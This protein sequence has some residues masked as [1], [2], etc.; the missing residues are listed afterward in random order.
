MG[1][2]FQRLAIVNRGEPAMRAIHAVR[3]LNAARE[4]DPE[5]PAPLTTIALYTEPERRSMFVREADEAVLLGPATFVDPRDGERKNAYLDY[6]RLRQV[7]V[8]NRVEAVWVGWGFVAEH[9]A[10]VDL[11]D[12]LGIVFVGPSAEVMRRLGDK[13]SSKQLAEQARVPVAPWSGGPV[14]TLEQ[15]RR[16]AE[17]LG[18]PLMIKATAGG[19]GRGIRKVRSD[20]ELRSAFERASSEAL[21]AF[22]DGT[23]FL[24]R[25]LA[26]ARHV[27]VQIIADRHGTA[28]GLGVR[29]CTIQ[30]RN[31]K[32]LEESPSPALTAEQDAEL[33]AAAVRLAQTVG[34]HNAG[35]VEF[36]YDESSQTFSFMEVN[37]R[38]QV[39]HPVTE[40]TTGVDLVKLQ[41]HVARG[42]RLEGEAPPA[43]GAAI[44]V[45]LNAEDPENAFAPAPGRIDLMRL[46][47]G[48]GLRIDTGVEAG[49]R[50]PAEFDSMI[51][52]IIAWG[53]NR[54]EALARLRRA[55][56]DAA[57]VVHGGTTNKGFL[58]DLL[59][60]DEVK[61]G[62]VD[63]GWLDR[64]VV[65]GGHLSH[66]H[67]EIA[68]IEA[69][70]CV[71]EAETQVEQARFM[72]SAAGGRPQ[73]SDA[74]AGTAE[75]EIYGQRYRPGIYRLGPRRFRLE[76]DGHWIDV[77]REKLGDFERWLTIAGQRYR[78]L[79]VDQEVAHLVEVEGVPHRVS[80]DEGGLV[81]A[82][83]PAVVVAVA[84]AE[85]D[86]VREG[87]RLAVLEAMKMETAV[88]ARFSGTVRE[89]LVT[90]G[91]QVATGAALLRLEPPAG[92]EAGAARAQTLRLELDHLQPAT[93][94]DPRPPECR[95]V[96]EELRCLILGYDVGSGHL[97]YLMEDRGTLCRRLPAD[98]PELL[99]TEEELLTL[100]VD[101][102][103]LFARQPD[104]D[105][106]EDAGRLSASAYLRAYLRDL[107]AGGEGL[108]QSFLDKLRQA[109]AHY[110]I[111]ELER[112]PALE[113]VL[114]RIYRSQRRVDEQVAPILS[115]LER[116]LEHLPLLAGS[117]GEPPRALLDRLIAETRGRF[118]AI[119]DCA[120]EVRYRFF[121]QTLWQE[122]RE[123]A[124]AESEA[125]LEALG[126]GTVEASE[127]APRMAALIECP[128]P[129]K[130]FISS[131]FDDAPE[132]LQRVMLEVLTRRYYRLRELENL[133]VFHRDG[134]TVCV[135]DYEHRWK[136]FH[137]LTT[138]AGYRD[139]GASLEALAPLVRECPAHDEVILDLYVWSEE[140][141]GERATIRSRVLELLEAIDF[142]RPVIQL[143][144]AI[145][146]PLGGL[147]M[148]GVEHLTFRGLDAR[149]SGNL[150]REELN[151]AGFVEE[152]VYGGLHPMMGRRLLIW[153]LA[154]F[155]I[156]RLQPT[157]EDVYVFRGVARNNPRDERIFAL[158]E[159]RDLTPVR[160]GG[161][162]VVELPHLERMYLAAL[163]GIRRFQSQRAPRERLHWNRVLLYVW[164]VVE[165][166]PDEIHDLANRLAPEALGLG[167]EKVVVRARLKP[168]GSG[169][170]STAD[171][172]APRDTELHIWHRAGQ[173]SVVRFRKPSDRP[174]QPLTRYDQKVVRLRQRGLHDPYEVIARLAPERGATGSDFPP[175][176]F[177][178]YDLDTHGQL[179]PV[180]RPPGGGKAN[181]VVG[182]IRNFT[183]KVPEGMAR[184]I[185]L[186]DPGQAMGSLAEP[187]CRRILSA[188]DLAARRRVP[189]EWFAVSAGAKIAMDSGTENMDWIARV[190]RRLV[191]LT[192]KGLEVNIIVP[193]I[194]V[195]AQPY[196]N[197]EATMLMHTRG[198]LIMTPE[199][200]M[201]LTGKQALDY[202]GGVSAEDNQGI[203][204]YE[205]IM[206]PNGQ[207]Q[208]FARDL[209]EA[210][211]ILLRYYE[212]SYVVPGERFPRR[213]ATTDEPSRDVS[214]SSHGRRDGTHFHRVGDIFS[215]ERN[216]GR[217]KA[218][219]VRR[220]MAAVIDR[221]LPPLE[222]WFGMRDAEIGVVWD[223]HL[224]GYPV[225]LLGLESRPLSRL[226]FVPAD[227][228]AQWT[229][230]TLFPQSSK[231][232]ARAINAASGNRPVVILANLSGFDGSPE[233]MRSWQLEY[234]AEIG[235]AVVNFDGP[236]V[237]CVIS[238]YH[239]GA[240]VVFSG[241]LNENLEVA[242][243]EG[244][245]ASVIGG[246]PAA[247]VVFAREVQRRTR[248]DS[249]VAEL[250]HAILGA[251]GADKVRLQSQLQEVFKAVHSEKLS[252]VAEEFDRVH[253]IHRARKVGSVDRIIPP[254]NLR[255]YLIDAV[256]RGMRRILDQGAADSPGP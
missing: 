46:P 10:F 4:L 179:V 93:V 11:C 170:I 62:A 109:L 153:R 254:A 198:I 142:G 31:Q 150:S 191:E 124:Y 231:K 83:S 39:E 158:A 52:K 107:D 242:A 248:E 70:I 211:K 45:R 16:H 253:S 194:N 246:A 17:R 86:D 230:G 81:R 30:R 121:D 221:D 223:A 159:V 29:D 7:M 79:S 136:R 160:D 116:R 60:R 244:S 8:E 78:V 141:A 189:L 67:A 145:S 228:P 6:N 217:K 115:V 55:L 111:R 209:G 112:T 127:R 94:D 187:E 92:A 129:L 165:L 168:S 20:A 251:G 147:G 128:Q 91:V 38:L 240:F 98:D 77:E 146:S 138:H 180:D 120:R 167:I 188:L 69:A 156:E 58:L 43:R 3:E 1:T 87:D 229:S 245:F 42:G 108:P 76:I 190:L 32:V 82:V 157:E 214:G 106:L 50:V 220:V 48:P 236:M 25:L 65:A 176:D 5:Q 224:G 68:L 174:T 35:T 9:A 206:G 103:A 66:R 97:R 218:F 133:R 239:G 24:E 205:H 208:Y 64:Q 237:F 212:H 192:Q 177:Q 73:V 195:G 252:E 182:M 155:D 213:A 171:P 125:D 232:I 139:L 172:D 152:R 196:W 75:L 132:A 130:S 85:G 222:R 184:V 149:S 256:E 219:D 53:A 80:R 95:Q 225:S 151:A 15:A 210:C 54:E 148:S 197:A 131:R 169:V 173:G 104:H 21:K 227:G 161:G 90:P 57:V 51:A 247:A 249:R 202:S 72:A 117:A 203:G 88:L 101:L 96:F 178:E 204:G 84:V 100:F 143:V 137:L 163:S 56:A 122:A 201:V 26:G 23:V 13:I 18:Y 44:E 199:G 175:G 89:V 164:P 235:R 113:E 61:T 47:T 105:E 22:G 181:V 40:M 102:S 59:H 215:T 216:P 41:L 114:W 250:E 144:V 241:A 63:V 134:Q 36:L 255:G 119:H 186:G 233:S 74:T 37:A 162:R 33:R 126:G 140:P 118:P 154:H 135:A 12:E 19:G 185:L 238:R 166:R 2:N 193:G 234:G 14:E 71:Y 207:A 34:Y 243:L 49:D 27:E 123:K 183:A 200:A 110:G 28:W 226:G 99:A